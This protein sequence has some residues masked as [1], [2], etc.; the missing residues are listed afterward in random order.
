MTEQAVRRASGRVIVVDDRERVLLFGLR[1]P[2]RAGYHRMWITPGGRL[3]DDETPREAAARELAEETGL[4]VSPDQFGS[5]VAH[6]DDLWDA[7]EGVRYRVRD[8]FWLLRTPSFVPDTASMMPEEH[9]ALTE[10]RWWLLS[11]LLAVPPPETIV[12]VGLGKLV[13][14]LLGGGRPTKPIRLPDIGRWGRSPMPG[15]RLPRG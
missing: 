7:P 12:P 9:A 14:T 2:Q 3:Q 13:S 11:D 8:E 1:D 4:A 10:H 15:P 5:M 6:F